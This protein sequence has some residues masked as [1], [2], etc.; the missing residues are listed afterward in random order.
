MNNQDSTTTSIVED[1]CNQEPIMIGEPSFFK[2]ARD[3]VEKALNKIY[4]IRC[5]CCF[6]SLFA[7]LGILFLFAEQINVPDYIGYIIAAIWAFGVLS[8]FIA[9]PIKMIGR[10]IGLPVSGAII[11]LPF[12]GVGAIIGFGIGLMLSFG[13][14]FFLP[15]IVTIPYYKYELKYKGV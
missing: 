12:L 3:M 6:T 7:S 10:I 11:G 4:K 1:D 15:Y 13:M 5:V 8:S 2:K 9:C 14:V